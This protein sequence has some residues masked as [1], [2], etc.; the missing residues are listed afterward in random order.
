MSEGRV[1]RVQ[2]PARVIR[3]NGTPAQVRVPVTSTRV[4]RTGIPGPTGQP[5]PPGPS[6][7]GA[8]YTASTALS[9]HR[10]VV[11]AGGVA[12]YAD[13]SIPSDAYALTGITT[14]ASEA[15]APVV[16]ETAGLI[17][18]SGWNWMPRALIYAGPNGTLTQAP[19]PAGWLRIVGVAQSPTSLLVALREPIMR[20]DD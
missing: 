2:Q 13:L 8:S 12:R 20:E 19:P 6:S 3:S 1:V 7:A 10:L 15:G 9:G 17:V 4:V 11:L 16:V 5:G 14:A 18:E